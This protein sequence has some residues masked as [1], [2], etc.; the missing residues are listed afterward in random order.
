M[1]GGVCDFDETG[2]IIKSTNA[3]YKEFVYASPGEDRYN[4]C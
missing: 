1:P 3:S 4:L 2:L